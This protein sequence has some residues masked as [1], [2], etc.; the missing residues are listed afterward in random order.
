V[1]AQNPLQPGHDPPVLRLVRPEAVLAG[2]H[3]KFET[4]AP[5]LHAG[6][7]W[8]PTTYFVGVH[9]HPCWELYLQADGSSRWRVGSQQ[10][11]L[12]RGHVLAVGPGRPHAM[13]VPPPGR[14]HFYYVAV[15][16]AAAAGRPAAE[17][18]DTASAHHLATAGSALGAFR[19]VVQEV[20]N[21]A[22]G[23]LDAVA[24]G[25]QVLVVEAVRLLSREQP[26]AAPSV[27]PAV[28][29]ARR[30]LDER[31]DER[32]T[33]AKLAR[34]VGLS[35]NHL[36]ERF[37]CDVG[38]P[39]HSYLTRRRL[40]RGQDLLV[41]SQLGI[42]EIAAAVGFSS[43]SHFARTFRDEHGMTPSAFRSTARASDA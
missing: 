10:F 25:A 37:R 19:I 18:F 28:V 42:S 38:E 15:D 16:I 32:W 26:G 5:V 41:R 27:H 3:A 4:A 21:A 31:F 13:L 30:L 11:Q 20:L 7:Q 43:G 40:E 12:T 1:V 6:E 33:I 22:A 14:H 35:A 23:S 34:E 24:A 29:A 39:P 8:A 17:V 36:G 2:F 9:R